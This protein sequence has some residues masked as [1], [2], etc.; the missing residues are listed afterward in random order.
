MSIDKKQLEINVN[1]YSLKPNFLNYELHYVIA[2]SENNFRFA[3]W[4]EEPDAGEQKFYFFLSQQSLHI[5]AGNI[6]IENSY[7]L[8]EEP[9]YPCITS[10]NDF[11]LAIEEVKKEGVGKFVKCFSDEK[12]E[13]IKK[14]LES[15]YGLIEKHI[16]TSSQGQH[17]LLV[18]D[19]I[20]LS[21]SA[22]MVYVRHKTPFNQSH[23]QH[24]KEEKNETK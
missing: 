8:A 24:V 14:E 15:Q 18:F 17:V 10:Y 6:T 23:Y 4:D 20:E 3:A 9:V 12:T 7:V 21:I 13:T 22:T 1:I 11:K 5:P 19:S 16:I 2:K